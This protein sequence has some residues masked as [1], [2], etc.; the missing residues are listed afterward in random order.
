MALTKL[1]L[2]PGLYLNGTTYQ[3]AGRWAD[4]NLVRWYDGHMQAV[5]G[6]QRRQTTGGVDI[7]AL[8]STPASETIRDIFAWRRNTNNERQVAFGSNS[9]VYLSS[10]AGVISTITPLAA[11]SGPND[12]SATGGYGSGPYGSASYGSA[13]NFADQDVI[14]PLRWSFSD[15][16]QTLLGLQRGTGNLYSYTPGTDTIMQPVATAPTAANGVVVTDERI[17][18]LVGFGG[19]GPRLVRWSDQEDFADWTATRANQSGSITLSGSGELLGAKRYL[20]DVIILSETEAFIARYIGPPFIF[21]FDRIGDNCG[22]LAFD[23]FVTTDDFAVWP[24]ERNFWLYNGSLEVLECDIADFFYDDIN[25]TAVTKMHS[26]TNQDYS[27]IWWFYQSNSGA[28]EIDKYIAW[29]YRNNTWH[30]GSLAR[31]AM[32]DRGVTNVMIGVDADG[33]LWNHELKNVFPPT[34]V[35]A[36]TG[37]LEIGDGD[38]AMV[39]RRVIPDSRANND[40]TLQFYTTMY[41]DEPEALSVVYPF[42]DYIP[43]EVAGRQVRMRVNALDANFEFGNQRLDTDVGYQI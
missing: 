13:R 17:V 5:G 4:T 31:T 7:A 42:N 16:G 29:N 20:K 25:T 32:L 38:R 18:M 11:T 10:A 43:V 24:G 3:S 22:P 30:K 27:E 33:V 37:P 14:P 23:G 34:T 28:T 19:S 9:D 39:I 2:P 15:F 40:F 35:F 1:I 21:S 6:W 41:P 12:V 8:V 36:E 26:V